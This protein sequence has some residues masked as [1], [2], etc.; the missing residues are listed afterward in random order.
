MPT[1]IIEGKPFEYDK[2][3]LSYDKNPGLSKD[4]AKKL[5][6]RIKEIFDENDIEFHLSFGTLLGAIRDKDFINGDT[7]IDITVDIKYEKKI[8]KLIP[9]LNVENIRL[10]RAA[11]HRTYSFMYNK[12]YIDVYILKPY[13]FNILGIYCYNLTSLAV[14]K[15]YLKET[16]N[17]EFQGSIFK[18]PKEAI[19]LLK[20]WYGDTWNIPISGHEHKYIYEVYPSYLLKMIIR[21]IKKMIKHGILYKYWHK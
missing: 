11:K 13:R 3:D 18:C 12:C 9:Q 16:Q 19:S 5:L 8:L 20:F 14:P 2:V 17:I 4:I 15:K 7:D 10:C 21:F 1:I 6:L